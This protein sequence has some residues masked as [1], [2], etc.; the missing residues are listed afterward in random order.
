[1]IGWL[2]NMAEHEEQQWNE[3]LGEDGDDTIFYK[4]KFSPNRNKVVEFVIIYFTLVDGKSYEVVKYDFSEREALHVHS[5]YKKPPTKK[6]LEQK[7]DASP[8]ETFEEMFK[9]AEEIKKNWHKM[10]I[11]FL[12]SK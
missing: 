5:Y 2:Y 8:S 10:K 11:K 12:E 7:H 3:Y 9:Y 4:Y 6:Y 1:M